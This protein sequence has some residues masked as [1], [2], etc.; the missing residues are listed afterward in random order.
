MRVA[1]FSL[2]AVVTLGALS[3]VSIAAPARSGPVRIAVFGF[4]LDDVS[5]V[6]AYGGKPAAETDSSQ[7]ELQL[8]TK[9]A[10]EELA[11]SKHY[12]VVSVDGVD[13]KPV[14]DRTLR[15]CDGCEAAIARDLG[16][17]QSMLG[18]V[19]RVTQTDYYILLVIRDAKTG[20]IVDSEAAN[21]AGGPEGWAS[22]AKVLIMYQVLPR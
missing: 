13:A 17:Q 4:E 16:A 5:P 3:V 1:A 10:R 22:G 6:A 18:I 21:F 7:M 20:K 11:G 19:R 9:A 14:K 8:A 2:C 15:D 12:S